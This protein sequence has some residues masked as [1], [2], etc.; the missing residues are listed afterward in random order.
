MFPAEFHGRAFVARFGQLEDFSAANNP[1]PPNVGFD[2]LSMRLDDANQGFVCN[3]FFSGAGRT[4]DVLCAYNGRVYVLEYN[5]QSSYPGPN[6]GTPSRL[7]ELSYTI[8]TSPIIGLS[9]SQIS[10]TTDYTQVPAA[11]SFTVSN[12][13]VGV[14]SFGVDVEYSD[15]GDPAWVQVSPTSGSSAGP[16][17]P[18]TITVTYLSAVAGLPIGVHTATL[19]IT[20][21]GAQNPIETVAV[22]LTVRTV[23]PDVDKDGDVDQTDFGA[24]QACFTQP[25]VQPTAGCEGSDFNHDNTI[26]SADLTV[27]NGCLSG[28]GVVADSI[29]DDAYQ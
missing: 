14:L 4:I 19:T 24:L 3:R 2:V 15:Q 9:T 10:R 7:Y 25:G 11:D 6:W 22:S 16:G 13:G 1:N 20:D 26:T 17:D 18:Q 23:L 5:Q 29:C 28:S 8:P 21:P 12:L 27:F